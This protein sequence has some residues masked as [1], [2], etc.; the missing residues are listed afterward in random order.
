MMSTIFLWVFGHS[1]I[2]FGEVCIE[3][4][5]PIFEFGLFGVLLLSL[6]LF[7][8]GCG[9]ALYILDVSPLSDR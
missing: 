8:L 4:L 2:I 1:Y 3:V 5:T 9:S 6:L 7:L